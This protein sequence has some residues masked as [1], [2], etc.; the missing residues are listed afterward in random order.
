MTPEVSIL[1]PAFDAGRTLGA[2]LRSVQLQSEPRW[3]C[4]VVDDGSRD[5]T[6]TV[7]LGVARDDARV[8][9]IPQPRGGIVAALTAGLAACRAPLI[10]RMDADDLM[11]R[12]RLRLQRE[13]L[14]ARPELAGV[15]CHVRLFPRR[16]LRDGRVAYERWLNSMNGAADVEREAFVECPVAH[17]SLMIRS[18]VLR[19]L[20][21]REQGWPEDYD[22]MLRLLEANQ[23][24]GVVPMRL[25]HWRDG[26][27]RLSRTA[28]EYGIPAFVRCKAEFLARGFL[29]RSERYILWGYGDTGKALA[30]ALAKGGKHPAAILELHPGRIGQLI[31]GVR[32]V[33][34]AALATLPRLP[35]V[36]SV[37]GLTARTEIRA[38]LAAAGF[39]E[40]IDY[41]CAA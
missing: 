5:A 11:S 24:V 41:V 4:V 20:G 37:A 13:A 8:R 35:L 2:A 30:E 12:E 33:S 15:G 34:P 10:A 29:A 9:V 7:A 3:E 19:E 14:L 38:S 28:R 17:P 16:Q 31:R 26:A 22:L 40:L 21:Y 23:R 32:V 1:L 25:L 36:V 27:A 6:R 39:R 18:K